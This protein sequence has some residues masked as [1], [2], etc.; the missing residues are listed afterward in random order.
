MKKLARE[1]ISAKR[2]EGLRDEIG[3]RQIEPQIPRGFQSAGEVSVNKNNEEKVRDILGAFSKEI[4]HFWR[5]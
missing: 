1:T 2:A 3:T 4:S 5:S